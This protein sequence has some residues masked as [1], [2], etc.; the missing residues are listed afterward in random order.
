M[1]HVLRRQMLRPYRRPLILFT[2][3][4]LL[5]HKESTSSLDD[6]SRGVFQPVI[7]ETDELD[8][9]KVKR[10]VAC[11]GKIYFELRAARRERKIKDVAILRVEQLYPFPHEAFAAELARFPK[12]TEVFWCQEEPRN[13][14]AWH[15]IQHY[16]TKNLRAGQT[17]G[18]AL[19]ESSASPAV[20]YASKHAEQQ[21]AVIDTALTV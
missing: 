13:Q 9:A 14:G 16:L 17:L 7:A 5:R 21:R 3:K 2:P 11:S 1:F 10:V 19:R 18:E 8:A 6:L 4:S 15:R 20:G 12:A